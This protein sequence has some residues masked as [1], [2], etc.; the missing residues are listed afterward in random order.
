[1]LAGWDLPT[2]HCIKV[3]IEKDIDKAQGESEVT[4]RERKPL[5]LAML[6]AGN[7]IIIVTERGVG[8]LVQ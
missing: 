7:E 6:L 1:M 8:G 2:S 4:P 3:T 5:T